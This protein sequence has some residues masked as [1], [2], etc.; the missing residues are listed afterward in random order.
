[1]VAIFTY[2]LYIKKMDNKTELRIK[3]KSIRKNLD[4]SAISA[5]AVT[6]TQTT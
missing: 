5:K 3:A 1:M 6:L 4:I 2:L